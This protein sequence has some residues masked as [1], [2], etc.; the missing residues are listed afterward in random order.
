MK[1]IL[2]F[3]FALSLH[4]CGGNSVEESAGNFAAPASQGFKQ[5]P[6]NRTLIIDCA[7]PGTCAGQMKDYNTFNPYI[8]GR[9]SRTGYQF[10]YEPLYFYNAYGAQDTL[11][12]WIALSHQYNADFT[13]VVVK[14]RPGVKW[15]DGVAWT[16][17]DLVF[18]VN[19]LKS[20]APM[21]L[22]STDMKNWVKEAVAVD[23]LT[24]RIALT[25]P[26]PRFVF[27]YFAHNFDNG[28][29]IVPK[30]IWEGQD[31]EQFANFDM[32]KG[33]PV[34]S[35]PYRMALSEPAQRIWD[36]RQDWW[37]SQS[38]FSHLPQVERIIFLPYVEEAKRVQSMVANLFDTCVD[39]RPPNIKSAVDDNPNLT[40]WSGRQS[41]Y[42][43]LD[44]WPIAMG[45][46]DLEPPFDDPQVRWAINYAVNRQ[47]LLE[48]G[49]QGSG[50]YAVLPFPDFPAIRKYTDQIQD[51]ME[52]YPVG[53]HDLA[54]SA[55]LMEGQGWKKDEEG[56]WTK[57]GQHVEVVL[58]I[59]GGF[60]DIG[61][62]LV[63]QLQKAGFKA[64]TR[65]I[66]DAY[67]QMSQGHAKAYINGHAG[68][69]RDPYFTLRLYQGRFVQPTGTPAEQFWRW[70]NPEFDRLVDQM[71]QTA[72]EDP[73]LIPLF[74]QAMEI[75]LRELP[76]IPLLQWYHRIPHNQTYWTNWPSAEDPYINSAYWHRTFLLVL[77]N[78]KPAQG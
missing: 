68:S 56:M 18:T 69:V 3:A 2:L 61:P 11:M 52:K 47:Q 64:A 59:F 1:K 8:P 66:S 6:R 4:A 16:A 42:G 57:N 62:V 14:I 40:T 37:A 72:P 12:P 75:W 20:H 23:D 58:N 67:D 54:Q 5:V 32:G 73:K 41:P 48:V 17:H 39:M 28:V 29:P 35:G 38:G 55:R 24:A 25:A 63:A 60:Q 44:W 76:S 19:M 30:H 53:R 45:F 46:N 34:V 43:Y 33:W 27:S 65:M 31:P 15:S 50:S 9:I 7:D 36:L 13:E 77:L 51:L 22:F 26:N 10:E 74:R 70:K 49:W 21:L 78:L 71:G